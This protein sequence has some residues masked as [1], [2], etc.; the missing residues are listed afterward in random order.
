MR[1]ERLVTSTLREI[2]ILT[3]ANDTLRLRRKGDIIR[4]SSGGGGKYLDEQ[5]DMLPFYM[6]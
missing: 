4:A 6:F 3:G 5:N 1:L 2:N